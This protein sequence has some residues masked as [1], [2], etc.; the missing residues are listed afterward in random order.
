LNSKDTTIKQSGNNAPRKELA[1]HKVLYALLRRRGIGRVKY[2][3]AKPQPLPGSVSPPPFV[4]RGERGHLISGRARMPE[5]PFLNYCLPFA[6]LLAG[7]LI[8][9]ADAYW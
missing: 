7:R 9:D 5:D 6:V 2:S 4:W 3:W 1:T 8:L